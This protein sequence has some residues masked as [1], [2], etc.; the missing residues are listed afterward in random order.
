MAKVK[1]TGRQPR[2]FFTDEGTQVVVPPGGEMEFNMNEADYKKCEELAQMDDPPLFEISGG[3]GGVKKL[4]AKEQR[5]AD[6]K[7]AEDDRQRASKA[8]EE[9]QRASENEQK[10]ASKKK[11]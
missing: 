7:K 8:E 9:R 5:E 11:A 3:H 6:M 10:D 1:N 2:G 4:N